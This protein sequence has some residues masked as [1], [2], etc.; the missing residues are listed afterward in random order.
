MA[1]IRVSDYG[2]D[3]TGSRCSAAALEAALAAAQP[4][5]TVQLSAG[6]YLL[7]RRAWGRG[8]QGV[9][10]RG[11]GAVLLL[12]FDR[13]CFDGLDGAL[14]FADCRDLT[15]Q[16]IT[17][18]CDVSPNSAGEVCAVDTAAGTVDVRV[19]AE[20]ALTG[21]EQINSIMS[22][23]ADGSP[24]YAIATYG[25][26]PYTMPQPNVLRIPAAQQGIDL[27]AV[28]VG[29]HIALRHVIY[30]ADLVRFSGVEGCTLRD[31]TVWNAPGLV[32]LVQPRSRDFT[33][34]RVQVVLPP[35]TARLLAAN[36]DGVHIA[37]LMGRLV[38]RDCRFE[39]LGDDALNIHSIAGTVQALD[40]AAGEATVH[41]KRTDADLSPAWAA[42]GDRLYVH[43]PV[44]F[45][46]RGQVEVLS[47]AG[48]RLRYRPVS[49][50][51]AVGDVL[52]NA[53]YYA[54][55]LVTGCT[56][57]NTRARGLLLQTHHITVGNCHFYGLSLAALLLAPD[58]A[59]WYEVG[60][61]AHVVLRNN[62]IEKCAFVRHPSNLGAVLIKCSH[63]NY[64][65]AYPAGVHRDIT[66]ADNRFCGIGASAVYA[67]GVQ[68]LR[69][70]DNILAACCTNPFDRRKR[71]LKYD[72]AVIRCA[73][74]TVQGNRSDRPA[75]RRLYVAGVRGLHTPP[76]EGQKR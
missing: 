29:Q 69:I 25:R 53:A 68:G 5:D 71:S 15:V 55:T 16:D 57:K 70:T 12:H 38:M 73:D 30:G 10:L 44:T 48:R 36:A 27:A 64:G 50:R 34:E 22:M 63:E 1:I 31:V 74:V 13:E 51:I 56:V 67:N 66:V 58:I 37:G 72:I 35:H 59:Y 39:Q 60:P 17:L 26:C 54:E 28:F 32:F 40:A 19:A 4:G 76:G 49:G 61:S 23:D 24:D 3:P 14:G 45:L 11:E 46:P 47:F 9:T 18:D 6:R 52:S 20:F 21:R 43:D 75:D 65:R 33:F 2:A 42:P 62:H 8:L 41:Y 7:R